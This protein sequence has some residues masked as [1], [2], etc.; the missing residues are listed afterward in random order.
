MSFHLHAEVCLSSW[1]VHL[2]ISSR[3]FVQKNKKELKEA[4]EHNLKARLVGPLFS[5][6]TFP[7][8]LIPW[9]EGIGAIDQLSFESR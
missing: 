8:M 5:R 7:A 3:K 9:L 4:D 6:T 2:Q 1:F